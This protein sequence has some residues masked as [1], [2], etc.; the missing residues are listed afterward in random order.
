M[1]MDIF[2]AEQWSAKGTVLD[3][4]KYVGNRTGA[5]VLWWKS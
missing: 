5:N 2:V 3:T 4:R 1:V